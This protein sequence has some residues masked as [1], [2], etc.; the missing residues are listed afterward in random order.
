MGRF[1]AIGL[2][3]PHQVVGY[4]AALLSHVLGY[5]GQ[6]EIRGHRVVVESDHGHVVGHAQAHP[7]QHPQ[8]SKGHFVALGENGGGQLGAPQ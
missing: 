2:G 7:A 8:G 5:G 3:S 6:P 4:N 1:G